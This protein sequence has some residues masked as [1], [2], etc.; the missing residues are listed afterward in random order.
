MTDVF[1]MKLIEIQPSQLYISKSKLEAV[2][3]TFKSDNKKSLGIIPVKELDGEI[4]FV[5]GHT[6][7]LAAYLANYETILVEW[8]TEDLDWE[9]YQICVQWCK[10]DKIYSIAD[11][12]NRI[13][14]HSD[15][16]I[17]WYKRC[18]SLHQELLDNRSK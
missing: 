14:N 10:T 15:Y 7:A 8:E 16:E 2:N 4:I 9:M 1:E 11:L 13:I 17:L 12:K 18:N 3:S 6:R 5:D